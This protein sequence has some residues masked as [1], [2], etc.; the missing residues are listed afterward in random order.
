[1]EEFLGQKVPFKLSTSSQVLKSFLVLKVDLFE[2]LAMLQEIL[3]SQSFPKK[4]FF[5]MG[6]DLINI[7]QI[8]TKA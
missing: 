5:L 2:A 1:M 6:R 4:I 7:K 8:K 3:C